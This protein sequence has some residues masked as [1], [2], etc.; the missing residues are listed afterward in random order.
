M[1][2]LKI[3]G[4]VILVIAVGVYFTSDFFIE[5]KLRI[6]LSKL[7]KKDSLGLYAYDFSKLNLNLV[8]GSVKL[9]G[10]KVYPTARA[11]D[12]IKSLN[13]KV[14]VLVEA[15]CDEIKMEG[16]QTQFFLKTGKI[17]IDK[18][19]IN[20]PKFT[21]YF[22]NKKKGSES[23][24]SLDYILSDYFTQASLDEFIIKDASITVHNVESN[25]DLILFK[26][27]KFNLTNAFMDSETIKRFSPFNY[28]NIEF[29]AKTL[30]LDLSEDFT[31]ST[32][33]LYFNAE[34][35]TT[36]LSELKVSPKYS[37]K[38]FSKKYTIQKEWVALTL[39]ELQITNIDFEKLI[40]EGNVQVGRLNLEKA[41]LGLY[42]DKTK[43]EPPF[44]KKLL[45]VSVIKQV[46]FSFSIDTVVVNNSI[47][48]INEKSA[49]SE[50][51][52][53]LS[54]NALNVSL[55]NLTN[56]STRITNGQG[57]MFVN[58]QAMIMNSAPT[59]FQATFDLNSSVDQHFVKASVGKT[60]ATVFNK[61]L[62]PMM[63][64]KVKSGEIEH[65][66]L[67]Y[68]GDDSAC[69][70]T[71]DFEYKD[72]KI[73]IYNSEDHSKKQGLLSLAA[74]TVIKST[75]LKENDNSYTQ[76]VIKAERLQNKSIYPYIWHAVQS[77]IVYT[78]VP[79][80]SKIK[81]DEKAARKE[82]RK[83]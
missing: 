82:A 81:K 44:K 23:S 66:D 7:V 28:D 11:M 78:M 76:G 6:E 34:R 35:N 77:G 56:D 10:V 30:Y 75:N 69:Q 22:N 31:V 74:N 9:K 3:I 57:T 54:I 72:F 1:K 19:V 15:S 63:L 83:N 21:Y 61:V 5:K 32:Q 39:N 43:P 52:G 14:R 24:I 71:I 18:F 42:K 27:F 8:E 50:K 2:A 46:P 41:N 20:E 40:E 68:S 16:F 17:A 67:S 70:G 13:N 73:D 53:E 29:S 80:L 25:K 37:Q 55:L 79:A 36:T 49:L 65:I 48:T 60:D 45:P 58:A 38:A 33:N 51:V 59:T 12:S 4:V 26:G 47:I 62:E 64:I